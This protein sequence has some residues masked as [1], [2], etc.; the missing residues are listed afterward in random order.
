MIWQGLFSLKCIIPFLS[1]CSYVL[2][3]W[4]LKAMADRIIGMRSALRE[5][6]EKLGSPLS[7]EH[8]TKQVLYLL[9]Y[10]LSSYWLAQFLGLIEKIWS[11]IHPSAR[12]TSLCMLGGFQDW[13]CRWALIARSS[14]QQQYKLPFLGWHLT[15]Y[16]SRFHIKLVGMKRNYVTVILTLSLLF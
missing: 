15:I 9:A 6:L 5:N 14:S 12:F 4:T 8:I 11:N 1:A 13:S 2:F 10:V 7:W 3:I 16:T